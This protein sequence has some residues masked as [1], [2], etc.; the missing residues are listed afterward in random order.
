MA[1]QYTVAIALTKAGVKS[2]YCGNS[3]EAAIAE[4]QKSEADE[5]HILTTPPV[6]R[7]IVPAQFKAKA[8]APKPKG[9]KPKATKQKPAKAETEEETGDP[10]A[11]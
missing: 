3:E 11:D 10:L 1:T 9:E 5:V 6:N 4:A 7:V 8:K 2:I